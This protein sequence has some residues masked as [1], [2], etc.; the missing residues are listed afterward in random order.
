MKPFELLRAR[1][2]GYCV[3]AALA[4]W[5]LPLWAA[6]GG[7]DT[8]AFQRALARGAFTALAA[9]YGFGLVT[10]LTP[11][12]Y[13]MIA[14][15]VSVF[16]A[17]ETASRIHGALLSLTFVLGIV[18]L[19][20]P[21]GVVSALVGR[22]FGAVLGDPPVVAAI[23]LVFLGLSASLF[24]AFEL[25]LPPALNNRLAGLGGAGFGG[26]FLLGLMC[27][28]V[29]APC[30]GPF[31]FSLLGWIATTRNVALGSAA[32]ASYGLGLG[33]LFFL[34]GAFA[35]NLP[36]AGAWMMGIKWLGG[37]ALA[38]LALATLRDAL[39]TDTVR[40]VVLPGALYGAAGIAL[41]IVGVGLAAVH[42]AA[43][44]RRSP[45]A[46]LSRPA[47]IASIAP[48][49]IGLWVVLTWWQIRAPQLAWEA[50][51]STA[52]ARA[53]SEGRPLLIDFGASWCGAC[54]ELERETFPDPRVRAEG[55]RFVALHVDATNEDDPEVTRVRRKYGATEGLPVLLLLGSDGKEAF[56]FT[57]FVSPERLVRALVE[58]R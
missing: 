41:L 23:A 1:S 7:S 56:R 58:V 21:L 44:R 6:T 37:V 3:G 28:V 31:L 45:I 54:K 42:V 4:V 53:T 33:T 39:P 13:P 32:M 34:V 55:A 49:I 26:A 20:A 43:E 52:L 17:R 29:A 9:S 48:A 36:K 38:Y 10:S 12:V 5:P 27:G 11:C 30:V 19:F 8:G 24:G 22:G 25:A 40:K 2:V 47:K 57:E 51:E 50:T 14:I 18:C 46:R 16:G 15:T 35:V